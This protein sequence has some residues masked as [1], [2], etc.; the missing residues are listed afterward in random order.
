[1]PKPFSCP[2]QVEYLK[3]AKESFGS[4][5]TPTMVWRF[6]EKGLGF[7][8]ARVEQSNVEVVRKSFPRQ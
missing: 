3:W 2:F 7:A 6:H 8:E 5:F 1:V 4:H